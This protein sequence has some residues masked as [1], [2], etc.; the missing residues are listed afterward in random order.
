[1]KLRISWTGLMAALLVAAAAL[2]LSWVFA[3]KGEPAMAASA[4]K[5]AAGLMLSAEKA[6]RERRRELGISLDSVEDPNGTGLIGSETSELTTSLGDPVAKRTSLNPDFAALT[7][8]WLR[9]LGIGK[10]DKIAIAASGSFPGI[11]LA[12][13]SACKVEGI[14]SVLILSLGASQYGANLPGLS[15]A[16]ILAA[17]EAKGIFLGRPAALSL[18]GESDTGRSEFGDIDSRPVLKAIAAACAEASGIPLILPPEGMTAKERDTASARDR[19][20]RYF[21]GGA[22]R[23]FVNIGGA[24]VAYGSTPASLHLPNG[25][26]RESPVKASG[27]DKGLIFEFLDRGIPVIHF[28]N[29]KGMA[30]ANGLPIDPVPF[31]AIGTSPIYKRTKPAKLPAVLGLVTGILILTWKNFSATFRARRRK[32]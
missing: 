18:G 5:E 21:S 16:E 25:I 10:G 2:G 19:L 32:P 6:V 11:L 30:L 15:N 31:P 12:V 17:L 22:P 3:A 27:G 9:E 26:I 28:L 8:S 20:E 23:L 13:L 1:M 4:M 24:E 29:I 14:E 7:L